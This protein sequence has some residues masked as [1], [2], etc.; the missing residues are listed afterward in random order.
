MNVAEVSLELEMSSAIEFNQRKARL[1][2][3]SHE[4]TECYG[5]FRTQR[6]IVEQ[7]SG[8]GYN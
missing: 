1:C 6:C 5:D 3:F 4:E 2:L 8:F 7:H